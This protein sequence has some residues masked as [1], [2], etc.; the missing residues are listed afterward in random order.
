[1]KNNKQSKPKNK[2]FDWIKNCANS[3][4]LSHMVPEKFQKDAEKFMN[5]ADTL[6]NMKKELVKREAEFDVMRTNF[7]HNLRKH[8]ESNGVKDVFEKNIDFDVDAKKDG[9]LVVNL[10]DDRQGPPMGQP[11]RMR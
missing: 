6:T 5:E 4:G 2:A 3:N 8:L 11:M 10:Y 9:F 1:M 7:W